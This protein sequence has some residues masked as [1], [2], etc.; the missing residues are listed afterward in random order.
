M[1]IHREEIL[2]L[3]V[4]FTL[5]LLFGSELEQYRGL[6]DSMIIA[7]FISRLLKSTAQ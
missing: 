2:A 6:I 3:G 1:T 4:G 7:E 5:Y